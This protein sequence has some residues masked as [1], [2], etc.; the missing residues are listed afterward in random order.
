MQKSPQVAVVFKEEATLNWLD[1]ISESNSILSAILAVIHPKLYDAG[2]MTFDEL[3]I[4]DEI[5]PQDVLRRWTSAFN[6]VSVIFNRFTPPHRDGNSRKQWYDLL[7]SLGSY[8]DCN[9]E[10]PGLGL[11]L[12]YGPG[13]VVGLLGG[14]V[15]HAVTKFEG[16]RVCYAY[17][18]RDN[19]HEWAKVT[20][21]TYMET[22]YYW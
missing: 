21:H 12:E 16:E 5:Q 3:R 8:E 18:M 15:E 20:E 4:H 7:T 11:S 17:W 2:Q 1:H 19:V 6:G 14:T 22:S 10:L 13:T 9:M